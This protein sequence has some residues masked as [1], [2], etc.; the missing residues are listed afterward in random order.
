[1]GSCWNE[2]RDSD[3]TTQEHRRVKLRRGVR[4]KRELHQLRKEEDRERLRSRRV[5]VSVGAFKRCVF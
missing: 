2:G 4:G 5:C 3:G 1:M